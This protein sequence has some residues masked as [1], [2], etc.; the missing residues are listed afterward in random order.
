M[1]LEVFRKG[2]DVYI[3]YPFQD[4]MFRREHQT[5]R[6]F[7]KSYGEAEVEVSPTCNLFH[8]AISTGHQIT[9]EEYARGKAANQK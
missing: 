5:N 2:R 7:Q 4:V 1:R 3:D 6:V 8:D 9:A